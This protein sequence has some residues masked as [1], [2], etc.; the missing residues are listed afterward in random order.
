MDQFGF[1]HNC[2]Q[3]FLSF[4]SLKTN[5]MILF[6]AALGKKQARSQP[7]VQA[8]NNKRKCMASCSAVMSNTTITT[9]PLAAAEPSLR[10]SGEEEV[11]LI[12]QTNPDSH[13]LG[14]N[15]IRQEAEGKCDLLCAQERALES[16]GPYYQVGPSFNPITIYLGA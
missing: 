15:K 11:H 1:F 10:G 3:N 16:H 14:A 2:L 4:S 6:S 5:S 12:L 7:C 8:S 9:E 13:A